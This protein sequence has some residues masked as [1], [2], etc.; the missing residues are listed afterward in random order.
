[1]T[2]L[3]VGA[4]ALKTARRLQDDGYQVTALDKRTTTTDVPNSIKFIEAN[5]MT[6]TPDQYYDMVLLKNSAQF[7]DKDKLINKLIQMSPKIIA[8]RTY[9]GPPDPD[10]E[11][12][13]S[14][15]YYTSNDL[16]FPGYIT[17]VLRQYK[18]KGVDMKGVNR[19]FC[20]TDYIGVKESIIPKT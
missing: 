2:V 3:D 20:T 6:W 11:V 14:M 19:V 5:F 12:T 16:T 8:I 4:G 10:F 7:M 9:Y 15:T 1:M 13:Y 17:K 18:R